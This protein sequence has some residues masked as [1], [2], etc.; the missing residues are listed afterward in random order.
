MYKI[1]VVGDEASVYGFLSLGL[2][3]FY[4]NT[5]EEAR[6]TL[7]DLA[8]RDYAIIYITER[9]ASGAKSVIDELGEGYLP[10]I[11]PIPGITGN[12]GLGMG[13]ILDAVKRAVGA[14]I[15]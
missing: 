9:A 8:G 13:G 12:E 3:V 14:D 2:D 15:L 5:G 7:S 4:V 10:A 6:Q 1:A 11:I